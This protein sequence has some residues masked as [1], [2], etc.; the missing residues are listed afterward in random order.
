MR[1]WR[2]TRR[3]SR[4]APTR[5][6]CTDATASCK[7]HGMRETSLYPA[8]KRFLETAGFCVK[9]EV[10]GCDVVA[11]EDGDQ[12]RLAIVEMKRGLNLDLLLQAVERIR[13]PDD[14][15]HW[16][17]RM[18]TTGRSTYRAVLTQARKRQRDMAGDLTASDLLG[19]ER[20]LERI[21]GHLREAG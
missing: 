17:N 2:R 14:K 18:T 11:V 6:C 19:L 5:H 15:R 20:T 10:N 7:L 16:I 13:D 9:G 8:V 12:Q 1:R 21:N 4:S 3:P